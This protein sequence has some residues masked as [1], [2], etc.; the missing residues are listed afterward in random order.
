[1]IIRCKSC[2]KNIRYDIALRKLHCGQCGSSFDP[3]EFPDESATFDARSYTCQSCGAELISTEDTEATSFC[4]Y[5]GSTSILTGRIEKIKK[6][7]GI[8]PFR[9]TREQCR[10]IYL[11]KAK[12]TFMAPGWLRDEKCVNSFR[13]IY[14]PY[15]F[16]KIKASG[17][18]RK[19]ETTTQRDGDYLVETTTKYESESFN[20][21]IA[22]WSHDASEA[23]ADDISE[24]M[25]FNQVDE[26]ELRPFHEG[27]LSGFYADLADEKT[28]KHKKIAAEEM[29]ARLEE[30]GRRFSGDI[31]VSQNRLNYMPVWFMSTRN[32]D[33]ITYAAI[34]GYTGKIVADF[35]IST[36]KFLLA[37]AAAAAVLAAVLSLALVLRPEPAFWISAILTLAGLIYCGREEGKL[38]D[39]AEAAGIPMGK[40]VK[41]L[42]NGKVS[43]RLVT[44]LLTAVLLIVLIAVNPMFIGLLWICVILNTLVPRRTIN[45]SG[46]GKIPSQLLISIA[47][48]VLAGLLVLSRNNLVIYSVVLFYAAVLSSYCI[49]VFRVHQKVSGRRPPQFNRKGAEH[50]A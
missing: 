15:W 40:Q 49:S 46:N 24:M 21:D 22:T 31:F 32:R 13:A 29:Q 16:Y 25:D 20:R 37:A 44:G 2:G 45:L 36:R 28:K 19:S 14:M 6:P 50:D 35:P 5:C 17:H 11:K 39:L 41:L 33:R 4:S 9:I 18:L 7:D 23:F 42:K 47:L 12:K 34:N 30:S 1:M 27:Y 38:R 26:K 43:L 3:E 10:E 8:L 48:C